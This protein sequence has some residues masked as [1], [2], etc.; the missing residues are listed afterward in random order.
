MHGKLSEKSPM[1]LERIEGCAYQSNELGR[2]HFTLSKTSII[3]WSWHESMKGVV[4]IQ[5]YW[6]GNEEVLDEKPQSEFNYTVSFFS[7]ILDVIYRA[8]TWGFRMKH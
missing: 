3:S 4:Y 1:K 7:K 5:D 2:N 6:M 8:L